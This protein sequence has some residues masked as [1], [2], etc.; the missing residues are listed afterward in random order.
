MLRLR[1]HRGTDPDP[2][3]VPLALRHAAEERHD[4]VVGLVVRIDR[5]ADL[6][7]PQR[8]AV[9]GEHREGVAEL[10]AIER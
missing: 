6:G 3:P 9:V 2:D 1:G 5:P 4:Q 7:H 8:D 10:V